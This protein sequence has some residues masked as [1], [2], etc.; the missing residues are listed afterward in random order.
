MEEL[1]PPDGMRLAAMNKKVLS[2]TDIC[3]KFITPAVTATGW[4]E[5]SQVRREVS[6]TKGRII[7][8]GKLVTRGKVERADYILYYKPNIPIALIEAKDN[9]H[10]VGAGIQQALK[11]AATLDIPFV[12]S[13]NGDAFLF[14]DRTGQSG[15][16]ETELPLGAFPTPAQLWASYRS[17]KGLTPEQEEVVLQDY[18][19]DASGKEPRYYQQIAINRTTE[20]I[21]KGQDRALLVMQPPAVLH[22]KHHYINISFEDLA[23]YQAITDPEKRQEIYRESSPDVFDLIVI[24]EGHREGSGRRGPLGAILSTT[25]HIG[26][27]ATPKE[28]ETSPTTTFCNLLYLRSEAEYCP[29]DHFY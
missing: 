17:W 23:L 16:M 28:T 9:N 2:E 8:R 21:A 26:F 11:Y 19:E 3:S 5:M 22:K 20:A 18:Y 24:D 25:T 10:P 13:S 14:H 4:D 6:F 27:S 29:T 15:Q 7:V 1:E 12:F